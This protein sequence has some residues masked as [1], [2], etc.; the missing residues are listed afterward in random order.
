M[1]DRRKAN[2]PNAQHHW[3][4]VFDLLLFLVFLTLIGPLA[5]AF[6]RNLV[7]FPVYYA[8]GQ[9]LL[10]GR[11]DLYAPDFARGPTMDYRYP[12]FFLV[13]LIPLW[14][15]SYPLASYLWYILELLGLG[16]C[17]WAI[18]AVLGRG[19][20]GIPSAQGKYADLG[21][22]DARALM[23]KNLKA[24]SAFG[25]ALL[26]VA[27]YYVMALHYGNAQLLVTA[28]MVLALF[29]AMRGRDFAP[30][31]LLALAITVKITPALFLGYFAV[32]RRWN[33]IVI[34]SALTIG[35]NL[36]PAIYFGFAR[37]TELIR[38]WYS[39]VI[40][41]QEFHE[42]NGPINLSLKGQL[43]RSLTRVDYSQRIDGDTRYPAVNFAGYSYEAITRLWLPVDA[44]AVAL[45]FALIAG[46]GPS[47][48]IGPQILKLRTESGSSAPIDDDPSAAR[49]DLGSDHVQSVGILPVE[50]GIMFC[51]MLLV[52]PLTSKIYF[53]A[54]LWPLA[55][56]LHITAKGP[57]VTP[58]LVRWGAMA[59]VILNVVLPLLPGRSVQRLLLVVG[60]DFYLTCCVLAMLVWALLADRRPAPQL[61]PIS[62]LFP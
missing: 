15:L 9:S 49:R 4:T 46:L 42:I 2:D 39:R 14:H 55:V 40:R 59:I 30:A 33:L 31:L 41:D 11:T 47:G 23:R 35:F 56:I 44:L 12:P 17:F 24:A 19:P 29:L 6:T 37:N 13:S 1:T 7:D 32:K 60:V 18:A 20:H 16:A 58:R 50:I 34:A 54:L 5:I 25:L 53:I 62:R 26:G 48:R 8:A 27:Q 57:G 21:S 38:T 22:A 10:S 3:I 61:R 36:A 43:V 52:E 51:M 45:G 28:M